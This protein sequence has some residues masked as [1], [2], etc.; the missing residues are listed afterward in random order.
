MSIASEITRIN[1]NIA[2]AYTALEGKGA[3]LPAAGSQNSANLADTIDT[4]SAGGGSSVFRGKWLVPP[5]YLQ[6]EEECLTIKGNETNCKLMAVYFDES[7]VGYTYHLSYNGGKV[8]TL[9]TANGIKEYTLNNN[10]AEFTINST[11]KYLIM[12]AD[13]TVMSYVSVESILNYL[14]SYDND[15]IGIR[16]AAKYL[17]F[18]NCGTDM[19]GLHT[20]CPNL[21]GFK[22]LV[23]GSF[24]VTEYITWEY[25]KGFKYIPSTTEVTYDNTDMAAWLSSRSNPVQ[26]I[27]SLPNL[28]YGGDFS[29]CTNYEWDFTKDITSS[30]SSFNGTS[31]NLDQMYIILPKVNIK[32]NKANSGWNEKGIWLS[33]D[34]WDYIATHA[35]TVSGK[36][37]TIDGVN[38]DRLGATN[39]A[40]LESKGW[41]V[42]VVS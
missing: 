11:D 25:Y 17:I 38:S 36:T 5:E 3:T 32:F 34:N 20:R 26:R 40:L 8:P 31:I 16:N 22:A 42:S 6:L 28:P 10:K 39:K 29:S 35:P 2:A 21:D 4:I 19:G 15:S 14:V 9:Y 27:G 23:D 24:R 12:Y 37:I 30:D 18:Y 7:I 33:A 13:S 41:T 1:G